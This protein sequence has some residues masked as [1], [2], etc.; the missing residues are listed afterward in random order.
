M[1]SRNHPFSTPSLQKSPYHLFGSVPD[2]LQAAEIMA[3]A[4][5]FEQAGDGDLEENLMVKMMFNI[6]NLPAKYY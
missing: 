3:V 6:G 4:E 5:G 1:A 2:I